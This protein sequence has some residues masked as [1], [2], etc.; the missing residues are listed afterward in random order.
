MIL[1]K[2]KLRIPKSMLV[3][4]CYIIADDESKE[5]MIIDPG[6]EAEK[7]IDM[8]NL[9]GVSVKYI[10]LTHC[11]FDHIGA[12]PEIRE[13]FGGKVLI[14]RADYDGLKNDEI[15]LIRFED[16]GFDA[17]SRVDDGDVIHVGNLEF[18]VIS[19]P[20]HTEGCLCL[21]NEENKLL[22][23]GDTIF[24]RTRGRT[25][26]PTGSEEKIIDSIKNKVLTLPDDVIIYP[27]HGAP[28][29]IKDERYLYE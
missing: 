9:L 5:A 20:G 7:V 2:L 15:S 28:T 29:A 16:L 4:N 18:K 26:L 27:G 6:S 8:I 21:Y 3:T 25:D 12:V 24:Y 13:K 19:T 17:D 23:S 11:H 14:S 22:F 1:K 10:F